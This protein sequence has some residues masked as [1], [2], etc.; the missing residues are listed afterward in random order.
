MQKQVALLVCI[1][2]ILYLFKRD[3]KR[4]SGVS[5]AIWIPLI[6]TLIIGSRAVSQ[7][8][9]MGP[10]LESP[11]AYIEGSPVDR[12]IFLFLIVAA[13]AIL[14]K[15]RVSLGE[16]VRNNTWIVLFF[17]YGGIS[18]LWSDFAMVSFKRWIKG[19]GGLVV[20]LVILTD[21]NPIEAIKTVFRRVA[22]ILVPLSILFIKYYP[23][24]GRMYSR[25]TYQPVYIGVTLNKNTLGWL[26]LVCGMFFSWNL[27]SMWRE[28]SKSLDRKDLV[29][30]VIFMIM[31]LWLL[32]LANSATSFACLILA[33]C[34]LL[35]MQ[36]LVRKR[37]VRYIGTYIFLIF[38]VFLTIQV[39]LD[40]VSA[41]VSDLGRDMT[42]TGRTDLWKELI[43]MGTNPL[44][45]TGYE[46]F[47]LGARA[48]NFWE[49]YWW[50][51]NQA[52]NGYLEIYLNLGWIGVFLL[53]G[54]MI[55]AYRKGRINLIR[56]FDYGRFQITVFII[57]LIYNLTEAAVRTIDLGWFMFLLTAVE[58]P[59][60]SDF[61]RST[62]TQSQRKT[63]VDPG[64]RTV[65]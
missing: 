12:G 24:L 21:P 61:L 63:E 44:I 17:L 10:I 59:S 7:W 11:D 23:D 19:L 50:H 36:F 58:L 41:M 9:N 51:P 5:P 1:L 64:I 32:H 43:N 22:Y 62:K 52:H 27:S 38:F 30:D 34:A 6:W 39:S 4:T 49:E 48:K 57:M 37:N 26:C 54:I 35:G 16:I 45:G 29:I 2:F 8:L 13:F 15:R 65:A 40:V 33:I 47:W 60:F 53:I 25:W 42:F 31:I 18:I 46:S 3:S 56:G 14:A 20:I 55:A 28:R